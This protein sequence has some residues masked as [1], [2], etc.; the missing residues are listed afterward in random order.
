MYGYLSGFSD[1]DSI[2]YCP[3]CGAN[4][5]E[6]FADGTCRCGECGLRFGVIESEQGEEE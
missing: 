6:S 3:S 5:E 1:T 2:F 4:I